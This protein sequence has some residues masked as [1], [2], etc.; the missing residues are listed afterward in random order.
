M[1]CMKIKLDHPQMGRDKVK[2]PEEAW[3]VAKL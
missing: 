3:G 1:K 2:S